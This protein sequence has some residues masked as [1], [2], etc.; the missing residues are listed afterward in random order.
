MHLVAGHAS[1][2][3]AQHSIK[4]LDKSYLYKAF[5]SLFYVIN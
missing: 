5:I 2:I 4:I 1:K 3:E